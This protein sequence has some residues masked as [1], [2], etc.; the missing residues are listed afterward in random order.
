MTP[1]RLT[2]LSVLA[3][4]L[5]W[6]W[7][8]EF[9]ITLLC[10]IGLYS[11]VAAG[12]VMLTGVGGMTSFGQ[13]AFVGV[14]AYATAWV[15]TSP[16]LAAAVGVRLDPVW[17]PWF[18]LLLGLLVAAI[19]AWA[20]G[21][22]TL[23]LSGHYLPLATIAWGLSLYYLFGNL[24]VLG[25]HTGMTG[26]PPITIGPLSLA[27]PRAIGVLI[28]ALLL[29]ALWCLSNLL[30]SSQGR[31]IRALKSSRVMAE[32]M[33]VDTGRQRLKLF[34]LAALLA[35]LSGWLYAHLQ[36]FLNPTPFNLSTGIEYLFMAV[37]GGA[38]HLWG[39]VLGAASIVLLKEQLQDLLPALL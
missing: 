22:I 29:L 8:P 4:A 13:A 19:V 28:W 7:L 27:A 23:K 31:A 17:L 38:G 21:A 32:S 25:G 12:L 24:Q 11:M 3:L 15:C 2:L 6:A 30:D 35:A 33:G 36:R 9:T 39:A 14:G 34:V 20:L 1:R 16:A 10:Y 37:I 5:A 18:G 26:V